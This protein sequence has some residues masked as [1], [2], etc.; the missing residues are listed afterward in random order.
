MDKT[1]E[2]IAEL[3]R[4]IEDLEN[5]L[6]KLKNDRMDLS[7]QNKAYFIKVC[8]TGNGD[9]WDEYYEVPEIKMLESE[10]PLPDE[11]EDWDPG[12]AF[13]ELEKP[14]IQVTDEE[15]VDWRR[16]AKM[17]EFLSMLTYGVPNDLLTIRIFPNGKYRQVLETVDQLIGELHNKLHIG[18]PGYCHVRMVKSIR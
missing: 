11:D 17:H 7:K 8:S 3:D 12:M 6:D 1:Y 5:Q 14:Y 10:L 15:Y 13:Y 16:C 9:Y 4:K 2:E 18:S